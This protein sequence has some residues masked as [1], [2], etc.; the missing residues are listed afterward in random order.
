[1]AIDIGIGKPES[2][3]R[4]RNCAQKEQV[5]SLTQKMA[6]V[7]RQNIAFLFWFAHAVS[8]SFLP[9]PRLNMF[10]Y[11]AI[12]LQCN[13]NNKRGPPP[14]QNYNSSWK[15]APTESSQKDMQT[16]M[17]IWYH[18][19]NPNSKTTYFAFTAGAHLLFNDT[20][21]TKP[22]ECLQKFYRHWQPISLLRIKLFPTIP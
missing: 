6:L 12:Y 21:K 18:M 16:C 2:F 11:L 8:I 14:G 7:S 19:G 17:V 4:Q 20:I 15:I 1:M 9:S 10:T 5:D 13:N 22:T 3:L